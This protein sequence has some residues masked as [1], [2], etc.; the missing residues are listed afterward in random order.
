MEELK[1]LLM[2]EESTQQLDIP[3]VYNIILS[4]TSASAALSATAAEF[5]QLAVARSHYTKALGCTR[6]VMAEGTTLPEETREVLAV[7]AVL[8]Y[9]T[10][11]PAKD[12]AFRAGALRMLRTSFL[13]VDAFM[14]DGDESEKYARILE[15]VPMLK[16]L[17]LPDKEELQDVCARVLTHVNAK[18]EHNGAVERLFTLED[19]KLVVQKKQMDGMERMTTFEPSDTRVLP[20]SEVFWKQGVIAE[21]RGEEMAFSVDR[22]G[23]VIKASIGTPTGESIKL[24]MFEIGIEAAIGQMKQEHKGYINVTAQQVYRVYRGLEPS[25]TVSEEDRRRTTEAIEK[26]LNTPATLDCTQQI[27]RHT[28]LKRKADVDYDNS[29]LTGHLLTGIHVE[30]S[31]G[32]GAKY[33]GRV[34]EDYFQIYTLPMYYSYAYMVGQIGTYPKLAFTGREDAVVNLGASSGSKRRNSVKPKS[35]TDVAMRNYMM[36]H[37]DTMD[38][39]RKERN[40][41]IANDRALTREEVRAKVAE[42]YVEQLLIATIAEQVQAPYDEKQNMRAFRNLITVYLQELVDQNRIAAFAMEKEHGVIKR[43]RIEL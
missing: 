28:R 13:A 39:R 36:R 23:T 41:R 7:Y 3:S 42:P 16:E 40:T 38:R 29:R 35:D 33:R 37:I 17:E 27:E 19:L 2:D 11:Y 43:V 10:L 9:E 26:L 20:T 8:A 24:S 25:A 6:E 31:T 21:R 15:S 22:H 18:F 30:R 34:I 1:K 32:R 4:R 14:G 12:A 5:L